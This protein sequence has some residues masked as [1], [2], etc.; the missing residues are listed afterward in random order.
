MATS[1]PPLSPVEALTRLQ[2]KI[3]SDIPAG[4][5]PRL[6]EQ[7]QGSLLIPTNVCDRVLEVHDNDKQNRVSRFVQAI[8]RMVRVYKSKEM[9]KDFAKAVRAAAAN[10]HIQE[11]AD[12]IGNY[13]YSLKF[14]CTTYSKTKV[15]L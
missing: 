4:S 5:V 3:F 1:Q 2:A 15:R 6:A 11:L 14:A 13:A 10:Q 8:I 12:Q 9:I 7:C